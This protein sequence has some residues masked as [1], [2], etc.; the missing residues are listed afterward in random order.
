[1][2][3][4]AL[5]VLAH[6]GSTSYLTVAVEEDQIAG[7]WEIPLADLDLALGLDADGDHKVSLTELRGRVAE[8]KKY[9]FERLKLIV[10]GA[11]KMIIPS[12]N[13]VSIREFADGAN[14]ALDFSFTTSAV[15]LSSPQ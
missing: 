6:Q 7:R 12:T 9:V 11:E 2:R 10:D 14:T 13:D 4:V 1:M 15:R 8:V 5:H 3:A